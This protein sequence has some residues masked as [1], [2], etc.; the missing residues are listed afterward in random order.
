MSK[1]VIF[2]PPFICS[3]YKVNETMGGQ[4]LSFQIF[5]LTTIHGLSIEFDVLSYKFSGEIRPC[6]WAVG[7][8]QLLL[9]M[10]LKSLSK[11]Q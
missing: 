2:V 10:K 11:A 4:L 8:L 3:L 7:L 9:P 1:N 6:L 5:H